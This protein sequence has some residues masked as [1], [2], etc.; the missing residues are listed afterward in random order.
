MGAPYRDLHG[1][2]YEFE[3]G[4]S[5][6]ALAHSLS[7]RK[8]HLGYSLSADD[9][10][11]LAGAVTAPT[12][13]GLTGAAHLFDLVNLCKDEASENCHASSYCPSEGDPGARMFFLGSLSISDDDFTLEVR[14]ARRAQLG[15][16]FYGSDRGPGADPLRQWVPVPRCVFRLS[17]PL[18][19]DAWG[20]TRWTVDFSV[21]PAGSGPGTGG[22]GFDL[23]DALSVTF[24]R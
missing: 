2:V 5:G 16:F 9:E 3:R 4:P 10:S 24:C 17:P 13:G 21:P 6:W 7:G 22:W 15:M 8:G 20:S 18:R 23:S 11:L 12:D 19:T 1:V 14:G